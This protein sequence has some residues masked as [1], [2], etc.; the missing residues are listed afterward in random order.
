[1]DD[2]P[3]NMAINAPNAVIYTLDLPSEDIGKVKLD[4]H[5]WEEKYILKK[6]SGSRFSN[7]DL[8]TEYNNFW[9]IQL[10]LILMII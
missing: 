6:N 9:V 4:I 8:K 2:Q 1:M 5:P 10:V 3:L 7:K